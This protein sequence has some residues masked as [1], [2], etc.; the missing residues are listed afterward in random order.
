MYDM[1]GLNVIGDTVTVHSI[2]AGI[3]VTVHS[4]GQLEKTAPPLSQERRLRL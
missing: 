1:G 3:T 4:I 2:P